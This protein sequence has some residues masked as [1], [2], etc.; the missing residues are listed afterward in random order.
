VL[1]VAVGQEHRL[2]RWERLP[3]AKNA[4]HVVPLPLNRERATRTAVDT[5]RPK[6][7]PAVAPPPVPATAPKQPT[8]RS[9][10]ASAVVAT[11]SPQRA[12]KAGRGGGGGGQRPGGRGPKARADAQRRAAA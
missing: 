7:G 10:P 8:K 6:A 4:V 3:A 5:L 11:A 9:K 2:G 1:V 12:A